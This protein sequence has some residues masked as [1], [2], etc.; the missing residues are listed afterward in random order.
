MQKLMVVAL[1]AFT[2]V[3][4]IGQAEDLQF[5]I[6]KVGGNKAVVEINGG[7][8]ASVKVGKSYSVSTG[9]QS[10]LGTTAPIAAGRNHLLSLETSYD[11]VTIKQSSTSYTATST[12][13][14]AGFGWN[15]INY[16]LLISLGM[17]SAKSGG[18]TTSA[19]G[20]G[21]AFD[22]NFKPNKLGN[23][24]IPAIRVGASSLSGSGASTTKFL[25]GFAYKLFILNPSWAITPVISYE[26][27][28]STESGVSTQ[29]TG[30]LVTIGISNYF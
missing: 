6:T 24:V 30:I 3:G 13:V 19:S 11:N 23:D 1:L 2:L 14:A 10:H 27:V 4:K 7:D 9:E 15:M 18:V 5:K 8:A 26:I 28:N 22:W 21:L 25:P 16:E 29:T 20:L 17:L 12:N